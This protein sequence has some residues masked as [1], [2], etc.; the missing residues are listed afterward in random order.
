ML[1]PVG[2]QWEL[3]GGRG[4][5][6]LVSRPRFLSQSLPAD[7]H[8]GRT[9]A[10]DARPSAS[11]GRGPE[12]RGGNADDP[13]AQGRPV[14]AVLAKEEPEDRQTAQPGYV[15]DAPGGGKARARSSVLQETLTAGAQWEFPEGVARRD[16]SYAPGFFLS[17]GP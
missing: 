9:G 16:H 5:W 3:P 15:Q 13:K 11:R 1:C 17:P 7:G 10:L 2:A 8:S 14:S 12:L 6:K 4:A